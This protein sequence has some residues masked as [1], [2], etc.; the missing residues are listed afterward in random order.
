MAGRIK[1]SLRILLLLLGT[2]WLL[3]ATFMMFQYHR[4]KEYKTEVLD[5]RLQMHNSRIIDD[6]SEGE[7]IGSIMRRINVP[8]EDLRVTIIDRKGNVTYD[9][10]R[11]HLTANHNSRP[12]VIAARKRGEGH[13]IERLSE[14]DERV[15][16]YSAQLGDDGIVVR[17]AAPYTHSLSEFLR[18]DGTIVW[19]ML[20]VTL[21]VSVIG[22]LVTRRISVSISR[23]SRFSEAA[24][25]GERIYSGYSFP[26]DELGDIANNIVRLYVQRDEQHRATIRAEQD[27]ARMK[28]QLTN[29]IN[30][31]L[32]T[33]VASILVSLDLLDDHPDLPAGKK[34]ELLGR[35][36]TNAMRLSAL[37]K[38]LATIARMDDTPGMIEKKAV[39]VSALIGEIVD[40]ARQRTDMTISV[41]MP[42]LLKVEGDRNL[43][44]SIFRN[45]IDNAIAYSGGTRIDI[46]A[47]NEGNFCIRDNGKGIPQEHLPHIFERFYRVDS[48]RARSAGGTGLG[49]SIVRNA[50]AVHGGSI[51]ADN[52]G[53]LRFTF[54]L[55][56]A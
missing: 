51:I 17:S 7:D 29:N 31:E 38:D 54:N 21:V 8:V 37:L 48:G 56:T 40:D 33:P 36:R 43:L 32:K 10:R 47:D 24:E 42:E 15:Y 16:F 14:S 12:E 30:H 3:A 27:K 34:D 39:D 28:K 13:A 19:I 26:H 41:E 22:M 23:L 9:S 2:C 44:E 6:L 35:I 5:S 53:G 49:L 4:E 50:V 20:V 11:L 25:K 1:F 18:A 46:T 55:P 45:L 52:A